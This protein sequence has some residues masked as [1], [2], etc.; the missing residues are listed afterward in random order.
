MLDVLLNFHYERLSRAF[1][2]EKREGPSAKHPRLAGER[3]E[4]PKGTEGF[5][6]R[7]LFPKD[8]ED[9]KGN[10]PAR[11]RAGWGFGRREGLFFFKFPYMIAKSAFRFFGAFP[12][13]I[14]VMVI[15]FTGNTVSIDY[16]FPAFAADADARIPEWAVFVFV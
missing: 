16:Q 5:V 7:R 9:L 10:R 6:C 2:E 12:A 11:K 8:R 1:L 14:V 4:K 15:A 13:D 3:S